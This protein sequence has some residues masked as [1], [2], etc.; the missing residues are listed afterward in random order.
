MNLASNGNGSKTVPVL[1]FPN[2]PDLPSRQ[3]RDAL[4]TTMNLASTGN[5]SKTVEAFVALAK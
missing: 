3:E 4:A 1:P 2:K 5:G